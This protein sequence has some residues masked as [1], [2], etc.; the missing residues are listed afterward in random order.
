MAIEY[1]R[2]LKTG[3]LYPWSAIR[4]KR[5]DMVPINPEKAKRRIEANREIL[6]D[7]QA[8]LTPEQQA[9]HAAK[10]A[11]IARLAKDLTET[12]NA[13][14]AMREQQ[15]P[16]EPAVSTAP[17]AKTAEQAER[18]N[19][20]E[21]IEKDS[22]IQMIREMSTAT[23]VAKYIKREFGEEM[24]AQAVPLADLK[25]HAMNLRIARM[26]EGD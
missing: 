18:Q 17:P 3:R 12:E 2:Q 6:K 20:E 26:F 4:A 19:R 24:D 13:I 1:L 7:A 15:L 22:H 16:D 5:R 21:L 8:A 25:E 9:V 14:D 10:V 11:E 23:K